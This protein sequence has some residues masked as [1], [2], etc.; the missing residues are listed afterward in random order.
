MELANLF[1]GLTKVAVVG[2][3]LA[4]PPLQGAADAAGRLALIDLGGHHPGGMKITIRT[5]TG[6]FTTTTWRVV[7]VATK[8]VAGPDQNLDLGGDLVGNLEQALANL[9][10]SRGCLC[11]KMSLYIKTTGL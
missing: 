10:G 6:R 7:E 5:M 1:L 11:H 8:Q 3:Q 9:A 4:E 2:A